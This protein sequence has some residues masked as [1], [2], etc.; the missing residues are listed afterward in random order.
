[1]S[2]LVLRSVLAAWMCVAAGWQPAQAAEPPAA[3]NQAPLRFRRI[4]VPADKPSEWPRRNEKLVPVEAAKFEQM[5][6]SLRNAVTEQA[7]PSGSLTRAEY[8]GTLDGEQLT[9][10]LLWNVSVGDT[11]GRISLA[12]CALAMADWR[13]VDRAD[14]PVLGAAADGNLTLVADRKGTFQAS[15]SAVGKRTATGGLNFELELPPCPI[16]RVD[17]DL[18]RGWTVTPSVGT[19]TSSGAEGSATLRWSIELGGHRHATLNLQRADVMTQS[20][21]VP[22]VR[23]ATTYEFT[24]RGVNVTALWKLE[25]HDEPLHDVTLAL[26]PG[27]QLIGARYGEAPLTWSITSSPAQASPRVLLRLPQPVKGVTRPLRLD[28]IASTVLERS[29]PLPRIHPIGL[30]WQEGQLTVVVPQ[31]FVIEQFDPIHCRQVRTSPLP[32]PLSGESLELQC[33]A[34]DATV[35]WLVGRQTPRLRTAI[36]TAIKID[37]NAVNAR[38]L[39]RCR[40][41]SGER[42]HLNADIGAE[43]SIESVE[44]RPAGR[45]GDWTI[46]TRGGERSLVVR[47]RDPISST[48]PVVLDVAARRELLPATRSLPAASLQVLNIPRST[49]ESDLLSFSAEAPLAARLDDDYQLPRVSADD[50]TT[51]ERELISPDGGTL[52]RL[53]EQSAPWRLQIEAFRPQVDATIKVDATLQND[54]LVESYEIECRPMGDAVERI[55][56]HFAHARVEPPRWKLLGTVDR[57]FRSRRLSAEQQ[58]ALELPVAGETWEITTERPQQRPFRIEATRRTSFAQEAPISLAMLP[59]AGQQDGFVTLHASADLPLAVEQHQLRAMLPADDNSSKP[60]RQAF[61]Y[62]PRRVLEREAGPAL[63]VQRLAAPASGAAAVVD[64]ARVDVCMEPSGVVLDHWLWQLQS[65]E[66]KSLH[67]AWT[68]AN[69]TPVEVRVHGQRVEVEAV[70]QHLDIPLPHV[71]GPID[72]QLTLRRTREP[73]QWQSR[74]APADVNIGLPVLERE[75]VLWLPAGYET[76]GLDPAIGG[77]VFDSIMRRWLGPLARSSDREIFDPGSKT[78]WE[79]LARGQQNAEAKTAARVFTTLGEIDSP[80][81]SRGHAWIKSL[82]RVLENDGLEVWAP[83]SRLGNSPDVASSPTSIERAWRAIDRGRARIQRADLAL[84]VHGSVVGLIPLDNARRADNLRPIVGQPQAFTCIHADSSEHAAQPLVRICGDLIPVDKSNDSVVVAWAEGA[85][86][87][88]SAIESVGWQAVNFPREGANARGVTVIASAHRRAVA[89]AGGCILFLVLSWLAQRSAWLHQTLAWMI[90]LLALVVPSAW[91][92]LTSAAALAALASVVWNQWRFATPAKVAKDANPASASSAMALAA[93]SVVV[94]A[95]LF[96]LSR[97]AHSQD[98]VADVPHVFIPVDADNKPVGGIYSVPDS[99]Y[100]ELRRRVNSLTEHNDKWLVTGAEYRMIVSTDPDSGTSKLIECRVKF[101]IQVAAAAAE[102]Q[103]PLGF[104]SSAA[105]PVR[106]VLDGRPIELAWDRARGVVRCAIPEAGTY[107]LDLV[108]EPDVTAGSDLQKLVLRVP[109]VADATLDM[110]FSADP[111]QVDIPSARGIARWSDD[112]RRLNVTLGPTPEIDVRWPLVPVQASAALDIDEL[113]WLRVRPGS[114]TA[115]LGLHVNVISGE[116]RTVALNVDPHWRL[117][118][119]KDDKGFDRVETLPGDPA[120]PDAPR[121][122]YLH[123]NN[124]ERDAFQVRL[125][126]LQVGASGTGVVRLPTL[127]AAGGRMGR[128]WLALSVDPALDHELTSRDAVIV[129]ADDFVA[130]WGQGVTPPQLVLDRSEGSR[131]LDFATRPKEPHVEVSQSL[132]LIARRRGIQVQFEA[133]IDT[134]SSVT[135]EHRLVAPPELVVDEISVLEDGVERAS[136][137][138][139]LDTGELIVFLSGPAT[140]KQSLELR[141]WLP[142]AKSPSVVLPRIAVEAAATSDDRITLLRDSS[143]GV[144]VQDAKGLEPIARDD[145]VSTKDYPVGSWRVIDA[146]PAARMVIQPN[147]PRVD[148]LQL[149]TMRREATGWTAEVELIYTVAE[150]ALDT[151]RFEV[152]RSWSG[153]F[154]LSPALDREVLDIPQQDQQLLVVRPR[155]PVE[156]TLRLKISGPLN[157]TTGQLVNWSGAKPL[158]R[159]NVERYIRLPRAWGQQQIAWDTE[160]LRPAEL[161]EVFTLAPAGEQFETHRV[162]SMPMSVR[163]QLLQ[164]RAATA[165]VRL[166][167]HAIVWM[168]EDRWIGRSRFDVAPSGLDGL[169]LQVPA[170]CQVI[171]LK[172]EGFAQTPLPTSDNRLRVPLLGDQPQ[173]LELV[174]SAPAD[175][176]KSSLGAIEVPAI[177]GVPVVN[178]T[179]TLT[180]TADDCFVRPLEGRV[181][182]DYRLAILRL[183]TTLAMIEET[184]DDPLAREA[185]ERDLVYWQRRAWTE[186]WHAELHRI[187]LQALGKVVDETEWSALVKRWT[188]LQEANQLSMKLAAPADSTTAELGSDLAGARRTMLIFAGQ[189]SRLPVR[190]ERPAAEAFWMRLAGA[191]IGAVALTFATGMIRRRHRL[192]EIVP[193]YANVLGVIGG[194]AWWLWLA[195]SWFGLVIA[196]SSA[197]LSFR[198]G[199]GLAGESHS[200][201]TR[202][203]SAAR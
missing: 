36:G 109:P 111:P 107:Q 87:E 157:L 160:G 123:R 84:V 19:T 101:D 32:E 54:A 69:A 171:Q 9:G 52:V 77:N 60:T 152:P 187:Q 142:V 196:V 100:S 75:A 140:G 22:L 4:F 134:T 108:L 40:V 166:A 131:Q 198:S 117:L 35:R 121:T 178:T 168:G 30:A 165:Q 200:T 139:Q 115:E 195:P 85:Q 3:T 81:L 186:R 190:I 148:L 13:W 162:V 112:R 141:G 202:L 167:D 185:G 26:D 11:G 6:L 119:G 105:A 137:W 12:P 72:V 2:R 90:L 20:R 194:V 136:R 50:L 161:P 67:V 183:Q 106:G 203:P 46:D 68:D 118:P 126:F 79:D 150:G 58:T 199:L 193:R 17:L 113:L 89:I 181:V 163:L 97:A 135:F 31:P 64:R 143:V 48:D 59:D 132:E 129:P 49:A 96:G 88:V 145:R 169:T 125:T 53:D 71:A 201:I 70:D 188:R 55:L 74:I 99:F 91:V 45:V 122:I 28:A 159:G 57:R 154:T 51:A 23:T 158:V 62:E 83:A 172:V 33:F 95:V 65:S 86:A 153:P 175:A 73:F 42:F 116:C 124:A 14:L 130:R 39:L 164:G 94:S 170:D 180:T 92:P 61:F 128:R 182:D 24:G 5:I 151:L 80:D 10:T 15:W 174:Y 146:S 179:W 47:L 102:L 29:E 25:A 155:S 104:N 98:A 44:T 8:L 147:E 37:R 27:L 149:T 41:D 144:E 133:E 21:R 138:S 197:V 184:T 63:K 18:P 1:M 38:V 110:Q 189:Q 66:L 43:W 177:D 76:W 176:L 82:A 173:Q 34:P 16:Q 56:V 103:I 114:V 7:V 93:R 156:D 191:C 127:E 192:P 78:S 120:R